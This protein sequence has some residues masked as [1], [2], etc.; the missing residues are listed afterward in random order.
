VLY[1]IPRHSL[2]S[3]LDLGLQADLGD[4]WLRFAGI[5]VFMDG[6]LGSHTAAMLDPYEGEPSNLGMLTTTAD[7][8]EALVREAT[9]GG[10]GLAIH[11]IGDRAVHAALDGIEAVSRAGGMTFGASG[12]SLPVVRVRLEH[13]Q[14]ASDADIARMASLGVVASVQPFHAVVDRDTA[15]RHWGER[16]RRA[17]AYQRMRTAGIPLAL[18]SDVPIDT[19]DPLRII[20][21]AVTRNNDETPERPPWLPGEALTLRQ[22]IWAYTQGAAWAGGQE[23]RLGS[24]QRGRLADLVVFDE[25]PFIMPPDR[26]ALLPVAATI[27]GGQLAH[28]SL[29]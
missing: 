25:D 9:A 2:P 20:H 28:G 7:E 11:A 27:V 18:G 17:Y 16:F 19:P 29:S 6:A 5:K 26:L 1:Y 8:A 10:I 23:K 4:D 15:E 3:A 22:A 21:A 24:I 13:V 14:L 12:A